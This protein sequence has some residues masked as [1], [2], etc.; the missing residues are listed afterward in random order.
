MNLILKQWINIVPH[1]TI[2]KY[3]SATTKHNFQAHMNNLF[4]SGVCRLPQMLVLLKKGSI[5]QVQQFQELIA[6]DI[7]SKKTRLNLLYHLLSIWYNARTTVHIQASELE[8]VPSQTKLYSSA[9]WLERECWDLLGVIFKGNRDLR[10]I[11]TDYGL[12]GH[13]LRKEYPLSGFYE[14]FYNDE[15]K[16]IISQE[17]EIPQEMRQYNANLTWLALKVNTM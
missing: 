4:L 6:Y 2:S 5:F 13:P 15:Y 12:R 17:V 3:V 10:R 16:R 8:S 14:Y 11:L 9:G 7:P 1:Y